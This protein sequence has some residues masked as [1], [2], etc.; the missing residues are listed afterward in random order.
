MDEAVMILWSLWEARNNLCWNNKQ[1]EPTATLYRAKKELEEWRNSNLRDETATATVN[2][3][4]TKWELPPLSTIKCNTDASYDIHTGV[5]EALTWL[6]E[7]FSTTRLIVETDNLLV[8]QALEGDLVNY[9]YF[10]ALVFYCKTLLKELPFFSLSSVKKSTN[11]VAHCLAR[12][13]ASMSG[14]ME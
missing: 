7:R 1:S 12:A 11:Q 2:T 4:T 8:K 5:R 13:S 14:S 10:D 6:N 9:S 3:M